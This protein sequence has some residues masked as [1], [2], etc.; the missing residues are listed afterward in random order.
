MPYYVFRVQPFAMPERV[1]EYPVFSEASAMAKSLRPD[2][3]ANVRIRVVFAEN[4]EAAEDLLLTPRD[5]A[6]AG[7]DE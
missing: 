5:R 3:A 6:P 2:Q 4:P 7:E 1:A